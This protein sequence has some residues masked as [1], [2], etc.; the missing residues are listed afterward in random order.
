MSHYYDL[1]F[2]RS[3][4]KALEAARLALKSA[5]CV[6]LTDEAHAYGDKFS[7]AEVAV[8]RPRRCDGVADP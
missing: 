8:A 2:E 5:K 6:K 1:R 3:L 4:D 7:A